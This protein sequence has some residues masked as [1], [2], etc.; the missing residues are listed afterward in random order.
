MVERKE[1]K[2]LEAL[3]SKKQTA[4]MKRQALTE[5]SKPAIVGSLRLPVLRRMALLSELEPLFVCQASGHRG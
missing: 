1:N 5:K 4:T 3:R 2:T